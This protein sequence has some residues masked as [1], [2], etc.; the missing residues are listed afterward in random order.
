[1]PRDE[2]RESPRKR[3][4]AVSALRV[5]AHLSFVFLPVYLAASLGPSLWLLP[6]WLWFG[7][8]MHGILN[9]MHEASHFHVFH[10]R[11]ASDRLGHWLLGPLIASDFETYRQ[12]HWDHHRFAGEENDTKD[13]YLLDL[14]GRRF[15]AFLLR[16]LFLR[17]AIVK[18]RK[19]R[20]EGNAGTERKNSPARTAWMVRTLVVQFLFGLSLLATAAATHGSAGWTMWLS[21]LL[22]WGFVYAYGLMSLTLFI[23]S[24]RSVAEHGPGPEGEPGATTTGRAWMRNMRCGALGRLLMGCYGFAE[25]ATHHRSPAVPA[26]LLPAETA[27]LVAS[28]AAEFEAHTSFAGRLLACLRS[29]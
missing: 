6:L 26:Y 1:M 19:T 23:A 9:L 17:E 10:A 11:A 21:A 16:C 22:A 24:L 15:A 28:G 25:H 12:R 29:A 3:P 13:A 20:I 8:S 27:R 18:F 2:S 14:R 4:D 5:A 7:L